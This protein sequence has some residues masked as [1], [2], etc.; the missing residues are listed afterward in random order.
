MS[1]LKWNV[2]VT[3]GAGYVG[4]VLIPKLQAAKYV[5]VEDSPRL[6]GRIPGRSVADARDISR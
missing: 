2:M 6:G 1:D 3:G 5:V 4:S